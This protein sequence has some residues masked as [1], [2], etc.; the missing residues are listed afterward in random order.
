MKYFTIVGAIDEEVLKDFYKFCDKL[1][2][3]DIVVVRVSSGGGDPDVALAI[4]GI[5][6]ACKN[7]QWV[8]EG[9]GYLYSAA[10]LIFCA[11]ARRR[12]SYAAWT[13]VHE[14]SDK[15][16]GNAST[17]KDFAKS[18]ARTED[19]W[20]LLMEQYTG[21][22]ANTW[23]KLSERD[24]YFSADEALKLGIATEIIK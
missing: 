19:H 7:V 5:I 16:K 18:M 15:V 20:N 2:D 6:N 13:M 1:Q 3:N 24:M 11:G 21:T 8:T 10:V 23:A 9:Y 12:I 14:G 17:I 22:P 4:V